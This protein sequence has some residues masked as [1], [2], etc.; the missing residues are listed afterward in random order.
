MEPFQYL[1]EELDA[2]KFA[3]NYH[4]W[5]LSEFR[6]FL[7]KTCVEVGAGRG[8]FT[9]LLLMETEKLYAVEPDVENVR[10]LNQIA[11]KNAEGKMVVINDYFKSSYI[12]AKADSLVYVNV[13]EHIENDVEELKNALTV[14]NKNGYV[15]VFVPAIEALYG[16]VDS[17]LGHYRRY[18]KK[19]LKKNFQKE[20]KL[21]IRKMK[22]FD[23]PGIIPW[24]INARLLKKA[25]LSTISVKL[26]D[27]LVIPIIKPI[28]T[29][30]PPPIGKNLLIVARK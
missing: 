1:G 19:R 15:C 25:N 13:L 22:Y 30:I 29:F 9:E 20:L 24:Y 17:K 27:R 14:L 8:S 23:F 3:K 4:Q 26:Y 18:S 10:H 11:K 6:D 2:M 16:E 21:E 28:E 12:S 7:G 5:I